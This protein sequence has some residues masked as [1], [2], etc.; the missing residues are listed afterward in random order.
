MLQN[1]SLVIEAHDLPEQVIGR[2][3]A[4]GQQAVG[5]G[6]RVKGQWIA[7]G[8][9]ARKVIAEGAQLAQH[10]LFE[11]R[12]GVDFGA[13]EAHGVARVGGHEGQVL[14][15]GAQGGFGVKHDDGVLGRDAQIG[16]QVERAVLLL[17]GLPAPDGRKAGAAAGFD[18]EKDAQKPH[19]AQ[20]QEDLSIDVAGPALER[21]RHLAQTVTAH[22]PVDGINPVEIAVDLR[23]Q[24]I[25][26]VKDE[27][28]DAALVVQPRHLGDDVFRAALAEARAGNHAVHGGDA[29]VV[30]GAKAA[31]AAHQVRGGN[32]R[33]Q[34]SRTR[35][36]RP[37]QAV[38]VGECDGRGGFLK[39]AACSVDQARN[40]GQRRGGPGGK[41]GQIGQGLL[42]LVDRDEI[43]LAVP[44]EQLVGGARSV[45][46]AG[47]HRAGRAGLLELARE[48]EKLG[49][50]NLVAHG[51]ADEIGRGCGG[52]DRR[53]VG[54]RVERGD[55]WLVPGFAGGR[56]QI[57][58]GEV[59]LQ[60][61][62]HEQYAHTGSLSGNERVDRKERDVAGGWE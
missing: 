13:A 48:R 56:G 11:G 17:D 38:E 42:A 49:R 32:A 15:H 22:A 1:R 19:L 9:L 47:D 30:A 51:Q 5:G 53:G 52:Q 3:A 31:A 27:L 2:E 50:A 24:E 14:A 16:A 4:R 7:V 59:F 37:R 12:A 45:V 6:P 28:P 43:E 33:H 39:L 60:V 10:A 55:D 18:A 62:T 29:A 23:D 61:G 34:A 58:E 46:A 21:Q 36:F 57:T 40:G 44:S 26:V 35:T 20:A 54:L 41:P 8:V 25:V